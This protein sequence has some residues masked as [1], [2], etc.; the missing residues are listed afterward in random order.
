MSELESILLN[1]NSHATKIGDK[2]QR[3]KAEITLLNAEV[4]HLSRENE[5]LNKK[6]LEHLQKVEISN[7]TSLASVIADEP[8]EK[9]EVKVKINELVKEI[10]KCIALLNN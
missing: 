3:Q 10:D 8:S 2:L 5:E 7:Q 9:A 4:A 6:I 1:I